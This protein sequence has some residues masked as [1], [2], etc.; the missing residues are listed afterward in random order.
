[1]FAGSAADHE[2]H[3]ALAVEKCAEWPAN[4]AVGGQTPGPNF[5]YPRVSY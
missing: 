5:V 3:V 1:M 4:P 2:R